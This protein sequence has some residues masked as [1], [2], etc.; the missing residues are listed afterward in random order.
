MS[1]GFIQPQ[2]KKATKDV[3]DDY[4]KELLGRSFFQDIRKN[5]WGEI[6]KFKMHDIIHDLACSIVENDCVLANDDTKSIDK[7]TRHVSIS[8][9]SSKTRWKLIT[10]SLIEAKNYL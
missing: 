3:G 9:F 10:E 8:A 7:K 1:Q 4:F 6:K 2:N 5:K